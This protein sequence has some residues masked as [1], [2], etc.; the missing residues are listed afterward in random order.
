MVIDLGETFGR[1]VV[2]KRSSKTDGRGR[3]FW[4]C[5]CECGTKCEVRG[6]SL[7]AGTAQSC[8]C[9]RIERHLAAT[10]PNLCG[11]IIANREVVSL[12]DE[13]RKKPG[14]VWVVKCLACGKESTET[15]YHLR[16]NKRGCS[17]C[18]KEN[19]HPLQSVFAHLKRTAK[20]RGWEM[21]ITLDELTKI[22]VID[23]C[24]YCGEAVSWPSHKASRTNLDRKNSALGYTKENVVPCCW[25]CNTAKGNQFSYEEFMRLAPLIRKIKAERIAAI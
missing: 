19:K 13:R 21:T 8:G 5:E 11:L 22:A 7:R 12:S 15:T 10:A 23:A 4:H 3:I 16:V 24:H 1:L 17:S 6:D 25:G 2:K 20:H 14:Q 18:G 9:L